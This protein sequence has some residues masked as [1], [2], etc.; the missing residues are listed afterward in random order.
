MHN[1][2]S[3]NDMTNSI[4]TTPAIDLSELPAPSIIAQPDFEARRASKIARLIEILPEFSALLESD[5]AIKLIEADSFDEMILV[6]NFNDSARSLLIAFASGNN[7]DN[8]GALMGVQRLVIADADIAT[9]AVEILESDDEFRERILI[10]PHSFSVAG[11]ELAYIF[12]ARSASSQVAD[13]SAT[14]PAPGQ[15]LVS[16]LS[17]DGD[18]T[19]SPESISQVDAV[20]S[21]DDI[22]PLTDEVT[23]QSAQ[24][25]NY[26][27]DADI[28]LYAGPDSNLIIQTATA[29][30]HKYLADNRRIGRDITHAGII[31]SLKT[32][33][34]Q[35][36]ILKSPAADIVVDPTQVAHAQ[37]IA[38]NNAG[39]AE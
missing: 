27:I 28:F 17:R 33:A 5:P 30:L 10:A 20:L 32:A 3:L 24:V 21:N 12:H 26:N 6:Q 39:N 2:M 31:A 35:N 16:L 11:P 36:V 34:V 8:L 15:V 19:A 18:G 25:I 38:V 29:D 7:L 9:G 1:P 4:A 23:V 22:R 37:N 14:S 13:A